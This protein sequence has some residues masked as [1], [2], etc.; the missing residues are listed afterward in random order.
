MKKLF[1]FLLVAVCFVMLGKN[2][3]A[4]T[5]VFSD[6]FNTSRGT[7]YTTTAGAIGTS[8]VWSMTRSGVDW[9]ARIDP[10]KLDL[11]NDASASA[12]VLGW[13]F[14]NTPLSNYTAPFN[15]S[16]SSNPG[17]VTWTFNMRS[18][19]ASALSGFTTTSSYGMA[20]VIGCTTNSPNTTGN[21]YAVVM[22]GGGTNTIGLIRF[23][24]GLQG[25]KTTIVTFGG[26][27]AAL[28]NYMSIKLTYDPSTNNW[29]L[30]NR[31][32][33]STAFA[34]PASGSLTQVGLT[35]ADN[36]Y[37][38]SAL[39]YTGAYWQGST[40]AN[41]LAYFDNI[42]ATVVGSGSPTKLVVTAVNGGTSP[43]ANTG[44]SVTVQSQD[45]SNVTQNVSSNTGV[46][47]TRAAGT[48]TLGGTLT[49]TINSGSSSVTFTGITYNT[50]ENGVQ[51]LASTNS[52]MSLTAGTSSAFNVLE[53][54]NQIVF[55]NLPSTGATGAPLSTFTIE[56]RR[57]DNSVDANYT[58]NITLSEASGPG[59]IGGTL[60]K[61]AV[62]GVATYNDITFTTAGT[63]TIAATD[64]TLNVTSGNIV[65]SVG[66]SA[67]DYFRSNAATG[68]WSTPGSW[69]S[70]AD[71]S[72]G[73]MTATLAPTSA[74]NTITIRINNNI[75]VNNV[76]NADQL[77]I[78][79]GGILTYSA[80]GLTV[81]DGAGDD[82]IIQ[83]GGKL[84][85]GALFAYGAGTPTVNVNTGGTLSI[86]ASGLTGV[87]AGVNATNI[88][89]S[90]ASILEYTLSSSFSASG[91]TYFPNVDA[92]TIP[93]FKITQNL[94]SIG[95]ASSTTFNGAF[96]IPNGVTIS[97]AGNGTKVFR[98]GVIT[99][100]GGTASMTV[101]SG[102]GSWSIPGVG[103]LAGTN[104]TLTLTNVNGI[105]VQGTANVTGK[106]ILGATN[107]I[108]QGSATLTGSGTISL[109]GS[110][111]TQI[112]T[113]STNTFTGTY[114]FTGA[115][116]TIP[117]GTYTALT[118]NGTGLVLGGAVT[119]STL[120]LTSGT[121]T[122]GANNLI[123][124]SGGS[125]T[126]A[127]SLKYVV[128]D[129]AG[130]LIRNGIDNAAG[131]V[132]FPI[133]RTSYNP[134][135][136]SNT[137]TIDNFSVNVQNSLDNA[138]AD[139]TKAVTRQWNISEGTVG[140]SNCFITFQW[141][142]ADEGT[143]VN[144]G[145]LE[146]G[147]WNLGGYYDGITA[148]AVG[149]SDPA[150]TIT[151]SVTA[152]ISSFSPFILANQ[153]TAP[154]ELASFTSTL[155]GRE[156]KLNWSTT[157][158]VNNA[159]FD[160]ERKSSVE[161]S[162]WTKMGSVTGNGTSTVSH[163]YTYNDRNVTSGTYSYRLKQ[164]DNNGNYTYY[165]LS[166][167]VIVAL[168]TKYDLSQNYPNPFNPT[169]KINYDLPVDAK[170]S[171]RIVDMTGREVATLVNAAQTAG[172]YTLSFNAAS[173]SS[174]IYFYQI[175]AVGNQS[176]SK[177]MKMLLVK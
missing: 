72:T 159:G 115:G 2:A 34:D 147:H 98:N 152:P 42:T 81:N 134:V 39:T 3:D 70:S 172:S 146:I 38:G 119:A 166:N 65:I 12:N 113:Y 161:N 62:A 121:I 97:W 118:V 137:G 142:T 86:I 85:M 13:V 23:T 125:I 78:E 30:F 73:W 32:D 71:G 167:E 61:A 89:Y 43:S 93:I 46:T 58:K 154:V 76:Q 117:A 155:N 164:I 84:S 156:V 171:V 110:L 111:A 116:Q 52:G 35:V 4:Q 163:S 24:N 130:L 80:S 88:I 75:T 16:L 36:T 158:E 74:A 106:I 17:L 169:T 6:N 122:L 173:L 96:F 103:E 149:G 165:A 63:V 26:A 176:F 102:T 124:T 1:T 148:T 139:N 31:D 77:V 140:G 83:S 60:T 143:N 64:G 28:T 53:A 160:V 15:A 37:T 59:A 87:G 45:N 8:T 138:T 91:N 90:N 112:G 54:A 141:A 95:G 129:G 10:D 11:S 9:G 47:L 151:N 132:L 69:E 123:I 21:G 170:V 25:T 41:Q 174:G 5:T 50:I 82:I 14:G 107:M 108:Q 56:A 57:T 55:V 145:I 157:E 104:G 18:S 135:S 131:T 126:G 136:L 177:T 33:G 162:A 29:S 51:L 128:T 99:S 40:T 100:N 94:T 105:N 67:S 92:V 114:E 175:N 68:N 7:T 20:Y 133:G 144:H 168:P 66:S 27:P 101:A 22:G 49:G 127:S 48:G 109:S 44:F 153:G 150:F 19:R 120:N 79:S